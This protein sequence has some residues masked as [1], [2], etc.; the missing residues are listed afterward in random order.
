MLSPENNLMQGAHL[1]KFGPLVDEKIQFWKLSGVVNTVHSQHVQRH[2]S[3]KTI[4]VRTVRDLI[5]P[6]EFGEQKIG[7]MMSKLISR[8]PEEH[9]EPKMFFEDFSKVKKTR[10]SSRINLV[11]GDKILFY[12]RVQTYFSGKKISKISNIKVFIH[13]EESV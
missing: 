6:W 12:E 8:R 13:L 1:E 2:I 4:Q 11:G 3:M 5:T 10:T 7:L 9:L